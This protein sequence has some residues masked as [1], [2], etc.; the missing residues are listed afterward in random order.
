MLKLQKTF[1]TH[2]L[3]WL[4]IFLWWFPPLRLHLTTEVGCDFT[5]N[6][7]PSVMFYCWFALLF[8]IILTSQMLE[9]LCICMSSSSGQVYL[10][11]SDP[12]LWKLT[13]VMSL[14]LCLGHAF[15][16]AIS[17]WVCR[18]KNLFVLRNYYDTGHL[19]W[20]FE[21]ANDWNKVKML[22]MKWWCGYVYQLFI[23]YRG[24][25]W[26][27]KPTMQNRDGILGELYSHWVS[28]TSVAGQSISYWCS[29]LNHYFISTD[30]QMVSIWCTGLCTTS[31][32]N[33]WTWD[34]SKLRDRVWRW[35]SC[36]FSL[37]NYLKSLQH[38]TK[39]NELFQQ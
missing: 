3:R 18:S 24:A 15:G 17:K 28:G 33:T 20:G 16:M 10:K 19:Y 30:H 8:S 21:T 9:C 35:T 6:I 7:S 34:Y 38:S 1:V 22:M 5:G 13:M 12:A 32:I 36:S 37:K 2:L 31:L 26:G 23:I 4:G 39:P 11:I 25:H 29:S 14:D 27:G